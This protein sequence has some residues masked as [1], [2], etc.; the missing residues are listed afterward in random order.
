MHTGRDCEPVQRE[1]D[2]TVGQTLVAQVV[3]RPTGRSIGIANLTQG[4][5]VG[6]LGLEQ[7][8]KALMV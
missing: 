2:G 4:A 7:A 1:A 6:L 8:I 5:G 3:A